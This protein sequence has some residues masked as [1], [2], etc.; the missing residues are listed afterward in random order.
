[1]QECLV[2]IVFISSEKGDLWEAIVGST[3]TSKS[4]FAAE[5]NQMQLYMI[6]MD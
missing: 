3:V 6:V 2:G 4:A 5:M 1:M